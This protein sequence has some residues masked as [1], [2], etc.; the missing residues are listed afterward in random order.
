MPARQADEKKTQRKWMPVLLT[1]LIL[2]CWLLSTQ[3]LRWLW[4]LLGLILLAVGLVRL[5]EGRRRVLLCGLAGALVIALGSYAVPEQT[6][7]AR[8]ALL[9]GG[10]ERSAQAVARE[11]E[12][13]PGMS[14]HSEGGNPFLTNRGEIIC[15]KD[16]GELELYYEIR[17]SFFNSYGFLYASAGL[18][19]VTDGPFSP[20]AVDRFQPVDG[21]WAYL[22]LY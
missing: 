16:G 19:R 5:P 15:E 6:E 21:H 9:R 4:V 22:K 11:L 2:A 12:H 3:L 20:E 10:Y 14:W 8:F 13:L 1:V 17:G 7:L 18:D